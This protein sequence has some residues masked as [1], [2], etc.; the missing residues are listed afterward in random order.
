MRVGTPMVTTLG[1]REKDMPRIV[2][3]IDKAISGENVRKEVGAFMAEIEAR[4]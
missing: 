4:K 2:Q 3:F 1:A